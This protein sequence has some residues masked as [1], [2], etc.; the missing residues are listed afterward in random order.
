MSRCISRKTDRPRDQELR[1]TVH[2]S[3]DY[4]NL[5]VSVF[6][7][8]RKT[9]LIGET[10]VNLASVLQPGGGRNDLWHGLN[11][12]GKYAGEIRI[13]LTYYDTRP[14]QEKP[15]ERSRE[16]SWETADGIHRAS[17]SRPSHSVPVKRRPLPSEP[18]QASPS[19][20]T[21]ADHAHQIPLQQS[22]P[23]SNYT[24]PYEPPPNQPGAQHN[25]RL[26]GGTMSPHDVE[27]QQTTGQGRR[28]S[29]PLPYGSSS[30]QHVTPAPMSLDIMPQLPIVEPYSSDAGSGQAPY[31]VYA[32]YGDASGNAQD[33]YAMS[34]HPNDYMPRP[35]QRL[36]EQHYSYPTRD[37]SPPQ[38][39]SG[40]LRTTADYLP[41]RRRV[42]MNRPHS[43]S[44]PEVAHHR[45]QP[46][47]AR[48]RRSFYKDSHNI[49]SR[50]SPPKVNSFNGSHLD[51]ELNPLSEVQESSHA[52]P[53]PPAHRSS[54][55]PPVTRQT[56]QLPA[57][58]REYGQGQSPVP[59]YI[60]TG[61]E[62]TFP[63]EYVNSPVQRGS[64]QKGN[65]LPM[66]HQSGEPWNPQIPSPG[67]PHNPY[68][69]ADRRNSEQR[70]VQSP[71]RETDQRRPRT[72]TVGYNV[73]GPSSY[74]ASEDYR[75]TSSYHSY[76]VPAPH[77]QY[78][79]SY[80]S[81]PSPQVP[82]GHE[83]PPVNPRYDQEISMQPQPG[84]QQSRNADR[85]IKPIA[86]SPDSRASYTV[87]QSTP[88]RKSVSPQPTPSPLER[89]LSAVP[90][91]P[92]SFDELNPHARS[93]SSVNQSGA[94]Y[95][96]A[97][98]AE[99]AARQQERELQRPEGPIIGNDGRV[100]D[101]SDHLPVDSWAPEPER[102]TAQKIS[103]TVRARQSP[104]GAQP[105][106]T[107]T[108]QPLKEQI[109]QGQQES[110]RSYPINED[111]PTT[112]GSTA[113]IRW[114][115][116]P[117]QSPGMPP[118]SSPLA[119]SLNGTPRSLPRPS[120]SD[121][122]LRERGGFGYNSSPAQGGFANG[123]PYGAPPIPAK[124][125]LSN[126]YTDEM[127][128][129]GTDQLSREVMAIDIGGGDVGR[130][131]RSRYGL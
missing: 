117:R 18:T 10:W 35:V 57:P 44:A 94:R 103:V 85:I 102:K 125:S 47:A 98:E 87:N 12:K 20:L 112:P 66:P 105:M 72:L 7:D 88:M 116:N 41:P 13:E 84:R 50:H 128:H 74:Q 118:A 110:V 19:P 101:P 11:C 5:K 70:V 83:S 54:A 75:H 3:P 37:S 114:P 78:A 8:D 96:S 55:T 46:E 33:E 38:N 69:Y 27:F 92:D 91:S 71:A 81:L 6:N 31:Q 76:N 65:H 28:Y 32:R 25:Q 48:H 15:N 95:R 43:Y 42:E 77:P 59:P 62:R 106:P 107:A 22:Q 29:Q 120:T 4:H 53:P 119:A 68:E 100:I 124:V 109:A 17:V 14:K 97:A 30:Q 34:N 93:N 90:F 108:R 39:V 89:R 24:P 127:E 45:P 51:Y 9:D 79:S 113:R 56:R 130:M 26:D 131:R 58:S 82:H 63:P 111:M 61:T 121:Y 60:P 104:R 122:A 1:F 99:E 80:G 73:D 21:I 23:R 115:K 123:S 2:D 126:G 129:Y 86:I 36:Q 49:P 40:N 67:S 64:H 16:T 52:P